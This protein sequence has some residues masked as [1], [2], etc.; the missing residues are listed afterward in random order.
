MSVDQNVT[1]QSYVVVYC[2]DAFVR[3]SF[4]K[5]GGD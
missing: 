5:L 3:L 2:E 4:V 1:Y